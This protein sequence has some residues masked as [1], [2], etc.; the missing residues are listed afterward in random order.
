M[1][2]SQRAHDIRQIDPRI[3][4]TDAMKQASKEIFTSQMQ[5]DEANTAEDLQNYQS[6]I[7][8]ALTGV[9]LSHGFDFSAANALVEDIIYNAIENR[10]TKGYKYPNISVDRAIKDHLTYSYISET[11]FSSTGAHGFIAFTKYKD[12]LT[13][14]ISK[15]WLN[16]VKKIAA[17]LK[18]DITAM[19]TYSDVAKQMRSKTKA[20]KKK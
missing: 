6:D 18:V 19:P 11:V 20:V 8:D 15:D 4:W 2:V 10:K 13:G 16:A 9:T 12:E 1:T 14:R 7:A 3:S 17:T 5:T